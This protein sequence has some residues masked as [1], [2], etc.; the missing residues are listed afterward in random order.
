MKLEYKRLII[1]LASS[2]DKGLNVV[3]EQNNE[4]EEQFNSL[5]EEGWE[6]VT[7][8]PISLTYSNSTKIEAME[9]IFKRQI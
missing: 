8:S 7:S 1:R 3:I 9:Y 5:G 2:R 6:L 4:F